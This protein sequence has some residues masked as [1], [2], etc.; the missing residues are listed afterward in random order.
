MIN[1]VCFDLF[2]LSFIS[3]PGSVCWEKY[4]Q[5]TYEQTIH[6][7]IQYERRSYS[8]FF[9]F[10]FWQRVYVNELE[11]NWSSWKEAGEMKQTV[12]GRKEQKKKR[13]KN[14]WWWQ[15]QKTSRNFLAKSSIRRAVPFLF[16]KEEQSRPSSFLFVSI[17]FLAG[18]IF[19]SVFLQRSFVRS[20]HVCYYSVF[21]SALHQRQAPLLCDKRKCIF[22]QIDSRATND[23]DSAFDGDGQGQK[24]TLLSPQSSTRAA[25]RF[26]FF[27]FNTSM[28][29]DVL[30]LWLCLLLDLFF[31]FFNHFF[32]VLLKSMLILLID[33]RKAN[34]LSFFKIENRELIKFVLY[35]E[36]F[37]KKGC[38]YWIFFSI[39]FFFIESKLETH[40]CHHCLIDRIVSE[41]ANGQQAYD[42][43]GREK[44]KKGSIHFSSLFLCVVLSVCRSVSL[45]LSLYSFFFLWVYVS[46]AVCWEHAYAVI[47]FSSSSTFIS[48][49]TS[50][51]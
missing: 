32:S 12:G 25:I 14:G 3:Q 8:R 33:D 4:H 2:Y 45:A 49:L 48:N 41:Q 9:R 31:N 23:N 36:S 15:R 26:C 50:C 10:L 29:F 42:V 35:V 5:L 40:D 43:N 38:R 39:V 46:V 21:F 27:F 37:D 34:D 18:S 11:S 20:F 7:S 16:R 51:R 28:T 13:K 47:C 6:N 30:L 44:E 19:L 17:V 24:G 22:F 1:S